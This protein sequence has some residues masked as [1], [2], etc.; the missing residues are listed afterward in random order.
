M[1]ALVASLSWIKRGHYS[2]R[3][4][5]LHVLLKTETVMIADEEVIVGVV[6]K[7]YPCQSLYS[8]F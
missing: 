1:I 8:D 6:A 7:L 2:G 4:E 3:L 5:I